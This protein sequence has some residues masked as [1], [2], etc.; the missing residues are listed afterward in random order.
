MK[1][2]IEVL[3][4]DLSLE[5][6]NSH[7]FLITLLRRDHKITL[8]LIFI[9]SAIIVFGGLLNIAIFK[10]LDLSLLILV[11]S[12]LILIFLFVV[13]FIFVNADSADISTIHAL[14]H[15]LIIIVL[16][17]ITIVVILLFILKFIL[18]V[19]IIIFLALTTLSI[20]AFASAHL[21]V[22]T[23]FLG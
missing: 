14:I 2:V 9:I 18:I 17:L 4:R 11:L 7:N 3:L 13:L 8:L 19:F 1:E 16:H 15:L 20:A 21:G 22:R 23:Q 6:L 12:I 5:D 10:S